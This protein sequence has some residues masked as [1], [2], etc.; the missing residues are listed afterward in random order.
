[1]P[2]KQYKPLNNKPE[3]ITSKDFYK[4]WWKY[5]KRSDNYKEYCKFVR[6]FMKEK[7]KYPRTEQCPEKFLKKV[8]NYNSEDYILVPMFDVYLDF[9]D[10][11]SRS[12][13]RWWKIRKI[14]QTKR[15]EIIREEVE[16]YDLDEEIDSYIGD[17]K[18]FK[19]REPTLREFKKGASF[20]KIFGIDLYLKIDLLSSARIKDL[21][22][23]I[24]KIIRE[25]KNSLRRLRCR[26]NLEP[27][28]NNKYK[29]FYPPKIDELKR[30]LDVYDLK[31]KGLS[32][33]AIIEKIEPNRNS[34]GADIQRA[35]Y[36]DIARA[37][38]IIKNV[39]SGIFP[40]EYQ[41]LKRKK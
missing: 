24:G 33:S 40:G 2:A 39:E 34:K 36:Q 41:P 5:L 38:N 29:E 1:M 35:F 15:N 37:K 21:K 3:A 18:E 27:F 4:L 14:L 23:L 9:E 19:G 6:E 7:G 20:S 30:Y 8:K 32:I 22:E 17:F 28:S 10:V 26:V 13:D 31:K 11:F 25:R 16:I 12:F